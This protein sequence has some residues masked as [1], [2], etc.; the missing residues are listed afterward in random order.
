MFLDAL[1][2]NFTDLQ[3]IVGLVVAVMGSLGVSSAVTA[4][5]IAK[6][7]KKKTA[8][9]L[10]AAKI[11]NI[12]DGNDLEDIVIEKAEKAVKKEFARSEQIQALTVQVSAQ[13][14]MR[15]MQGETIIQLS[16]KMG[17]MKESESNCKSQLAEMKEEIRT[18]KDKNEIRDEQRHK[19]IIET[20]ADMK[21]F[22]KK[23]I[24]IQNQ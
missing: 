22:L 1:P 17:A 24:P 4:I 20:F 3:I 19:E 7:N 9:E 14:E 8:Q 23:C 2:S 10:D 21:E 5:V 11:K 12:K 6:L 15:K 18:L 16:E 13:D